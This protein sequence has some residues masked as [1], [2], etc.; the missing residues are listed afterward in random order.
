MSVALVAA[1]TLKRRIAKSGKAKKDDGL[2][3]ESLARCGFLFIKNPIL[4]FENLIMTHDDKTTKYSK[5][6]HHPW[7]L[8]LGGGGARGMAHVGVLRVLEEAG[9]VPSYIVGT[10][11][12]SVIGGMYAQRP[13][14]NEVYRRLTAFLEGDFYRDVGLSMFY[15]TKKSGLFE[16]LEAW[17]NEV[18]KRLLMSK[19]MLTP[20]AFARDLLEQALGYL[21]DDTPISATVIPFATISCDLVKGTVEIITDGS[22]ITATCASSAIPGVVEP[23]KYDGKLLVDGGTTSMTPVWEA[24]ELVPYPVI[25]VTIARP[26]NSNATPTRGIEVMLRAGDLASMHLNRRSLLSAEIVIAPDVGDVHW[27]EFHRGEEMIQAG[28]LAAHD[29]LPAIK[30]LLQTRKSGTSRWWKSRK[31]PSQ[32]RR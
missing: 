23:V 1:I 15:E 12:G 5:R 31:Q 7:T 14:T 17:V 24:K 13:D 18:R 32:K 22:I 25:A 29:A 16:Q 28:Q 3:A 11:I 2:H 21:L 27:S 10:S 4:Y 8:V 19:L 30:E 9:L 26:L 20:G 6:D